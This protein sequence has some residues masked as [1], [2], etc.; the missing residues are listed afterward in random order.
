MTSVSG[1]E[2]WTEGLEIVLVGRPPSW[3]RA[4]RVAG[5]IIYMTRE[6]KAWKEIVT[7]ATQKALVTRPD[8]LPVDG[9]RIV[10]D[11][12]AHLK[13]PMDADNLLKLTLDAVAAGLVV[14]DR[15]FIP[16]VWEMEFGAAEEYVRLV[17][18][19]EK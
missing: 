9:K 1:L 3:N 8:F 18:S 17:L 13:R 4:Y 7:Y 6:A 11:I 10:I 15:W 2:G 19:Q 12:W 16:R 14:N 5:K